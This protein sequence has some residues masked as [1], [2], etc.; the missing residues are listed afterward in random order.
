MRRKLFNLLTGMS[1][2]I[3]TAAVMLWIR[4]HWQ[5]DQVNW[6]NENN[7]VCFAS[8]NSV[9]A[10]M[11]GPNY[12]GADAMPPFDSGWRYRH[13]P[14]RA[15]D[16]DSVRCQIPAAV[17]HRLGWLG[18]AYDP[19]QLQTYNGPPKLVWYSSHR[20]YFPHWSLAAITGIL[21][22]MW[23]WRRRR[24][25]VRRKLGRCVNC[26]YDLRATPERCPECGNVPA[27][28]TFG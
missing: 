15:N 21:P 13:Y 9:M 26:G 10:V 6:N 23:C 3:F 5:C 12:K 16:Q 25:R 11:F 14:A 20:L 22:S 27:A 24:E 19:N 4:G 18:F 28:H 2:V 8:A 7:G 1:L 17:Y